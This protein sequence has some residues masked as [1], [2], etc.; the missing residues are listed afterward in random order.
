MIIK[1]REKIMCLHKKMKR[2][3]FHKKQYTVKLF[4]KKKILWCVRK[5]KKKIL[6]MKLFMRIW[7][8][9]IICKV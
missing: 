6:N 8:C 9:C 2:N 7:L 1:K 5:I 4:Y 3:V